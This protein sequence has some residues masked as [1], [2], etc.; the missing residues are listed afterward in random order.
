M[1]ASGA[2]RRRFNP[3]FAASRWEISSREDGRRYP[4]VLGHE[5]GVRVAEDD[6]VRPMEGAEPG[7]RSRA[8]GTQVPS[9]SRKVCGNLPAGPH[10]R[11][12]PPGNGAPFGQPRH[13]VYLQSAMVT[14]SARR[15]VPAA[16]GAY[17]AFETPSSRAGL[18]RDGGIRVRLPASRTP[19]GPGRIGH[20]VPPVPSGTRWPARTVTPH[21]SERGGES[22]RPTWVWLRSSSRP[23]K[24]SSAPGALPPAP[25]IEGIG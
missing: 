10:G 11:T 23:P 7:G 18:F 25:G 22:G 2:C 19:R 17:E 1:R 24:S 13:A 15:Y 9:R 20:P 21:T 8:G 5:G 16:S 4:L 12:P 14:S 6:L 3:V